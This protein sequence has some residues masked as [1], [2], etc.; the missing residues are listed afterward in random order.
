MGGGAEGGWVVL[1]GELFG[2]SH[3]L[4]PL[5]SSFVLFFLVSIG[6]VAQISGFFP[7]H[8]SVVRRKGDDIENNFP[9]ENSSTG[10]AK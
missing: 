9:I 6:S 1:D 4:P 3:L 8:S 5:R 2:P 10:T 7:S